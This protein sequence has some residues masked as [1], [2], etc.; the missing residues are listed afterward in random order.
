MIKIKGYCRHLSTTHSIPKVLVTQKNAQLF[1]RFVTL[2]YTN[3]P[4]GIQP[5]LLFKGQDGLKLR[6]LSLDHL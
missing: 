4:S 3:S 1:T 6:M 2:K 5:L